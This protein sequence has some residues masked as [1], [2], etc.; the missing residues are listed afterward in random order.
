M[1]HRRAPALYSTVLPLVLGCLAV[2]HTAA[3]PVPPGDKAPRAVDGRPPP[4]EQ[5]AEYMRLIRMQEMN[6]QQ[7][8]ALYSLLDDDGDGEFTVHEMIDLFDGINN[9]AL[10][11]DD[12]NGNPMPHHCKPHA[13]K[14]APFSVKTSSRSKRSHVA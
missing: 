11:I 10:L 13:Q 4:S 3:A 9:D 1:G 6:I 2:R 5:K 12:C 14:H 8:E 7:V